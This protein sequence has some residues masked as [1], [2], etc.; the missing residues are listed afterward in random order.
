MCICKT[1]KV[2][3][4]SGILAAIWIS[5]T[6]GRPSKSQVSLLERL[7]RKRSGSHWNFDA[8]F[9]SFGDITTSGLLAAVLDF[10]HEVALAMIAGHLDVSFIVI[11]PCVVFGTTCVSVKP[12]KLLVLPVI[13]I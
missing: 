6:H 4:T 11:N 13:W 12:A 3:S 2:I 9:H 10:R 1:S 8:M 5:S 7:T